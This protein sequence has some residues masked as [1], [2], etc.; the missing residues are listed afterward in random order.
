MLDISRV[1]ADCCAASA[2]E[3]RLFLPT[4]FDAVLLPL[5]RLMMGHP[6]PIS[7]D[8]PL[9]LFPD[10][11]RIPHA[12]PTAPVRIQLK[13]DSR[14]S[15][16]ASSV[17]LDVISLSARCR[18]P[19]L[20]FPPFANSP[21]SPPSTKRSRG[22]AACRFVR[23]SP[24]RK[25]LLNKLDAERERRGG[26][27]NFQVTFVC[28]RC[29]RPCWHQDQREGNRSLARSALLCSRQKGNLLAIR[30]S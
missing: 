17:N 30:G 24:W 12:C 27:I 25:S 11:P 26:A 1:R 16:A 21:S 14:P 23:N 9:S 6:T 13:P 15:S 18:S 28:V 4:S 20:P 5:S 8:I 10:P 3:N 7:T 22:R 2:I 19:S 29:Q